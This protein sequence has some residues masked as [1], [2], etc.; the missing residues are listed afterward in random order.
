[1]RELDDILDM[2]RPTYSELGSP[3]DKLQI[4]PDWYRD[5]CYRLEEE[6]GT[7][8][9]IFNGRWVRLELADDISKHKIER[10]W[11][12]KF[13]ELV[14]KTDPRV[15][16]E[17]CIVAFSKGADSRARGQDESVDK[18]AMGGHKAIKREPAGKTCRIAQPVVPIDA[19]VPSPA[20]SNDEDKGGADD[21]DVAAAQ[22][23][24]P[25]AQGLAQTA[26]S[27]GRDSTA[28]TTARAM[29]ASPKTPAGKQKA[30]RAEADGNSGV[31]RV[32]MGP[33]KPIEAFFKPNLPPGVA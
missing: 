12:R 33:K 14:H 19:G 21:K 1:M 11:S 32:R 20:P 16:A 10:N 24:A 6:A 27:R 23:S 22:D 25:V 13:A 30:K 28:S 8:Y 7:V 5:G 3:A 15:P 4:P 18:K 29:K 2:L 9:M 17:L 26:S 31:K